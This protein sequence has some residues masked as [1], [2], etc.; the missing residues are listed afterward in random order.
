MRYYLQF[1]RA[2]PHFRVRYP[3]VTHPFAA[4]LTAE[5]VSS[6]DL[7]VLGAPPAFILSQDQTL[8]FEP[9]R[10]TD[11]SRSLAGVCV[12][13]LIAALPLR[14]AA[15]PHARFSFQRT[16]TRPSR[17]SSNLIPAGGFVNPP[18]SSTFSKSDPLTGG[19][20]LY[21][22]SRPGCQAPRPARRPSPR[23]RQ[24]SKEQ[25]DRDP[26]PGMRVPRPLNACDWQRC[27][28]QPPWQATGSRRT[29]P[30]WR[31]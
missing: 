14:I 17:R 27:P 30:S 19:D 9:A 12:I 26:G 15:A 29:P 4:R 24:S 6:L 3:R 25:E 28:P 8:Q 18:G 23:C 5:A 31:W 7:H 20:A 2:I 16:S 21:R 11:P 13:R 1:P 22:A 10:S